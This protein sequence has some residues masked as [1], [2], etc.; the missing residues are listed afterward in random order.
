MALLTY[1][2][3]ADHVFPCTVCCYC[4]GI[5]CHKGPSLAFF[6]FQTSFEAS[7]S[8][9]VL[10]CIIFAAAGVAAAQLH[11]RLVFGRGDAQLRGVA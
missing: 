10:T 4:R 11:S 6:V 1:Y 9:M 2:M 8:L 7:L 5:R 3:I